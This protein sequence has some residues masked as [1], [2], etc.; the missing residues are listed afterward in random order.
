MARILVV[1]DTQDT[2]ELLHYYLT[3]EGFSVM[4]AAD[5]A[6]GLY[7]VTMER[8]DLV[9]TD[10]AMPVM[11]GL[12]MVREMRG[13]PEMASIPIIVLTAYGREM[14]EQARQSGATRALRKPMDFDDLI[15]EVRRLLP[16]TAQPEGPQTERGLDRPWSPPSTRS[17][18]YGLGI[19]ASS[20]ARR[21]RPA[22]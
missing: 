3:R 7:R 17:N 9:I 11:D 22:S 5:G 13:T 21:G 2:R 15:A 8:P 14:A 10:V 6:E 12:M 1:D 19:A 20:P 16:P 18:G 4:I